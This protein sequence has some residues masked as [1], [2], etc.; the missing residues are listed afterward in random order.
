MKLSAREQ[1]KIKS[2]TYKIVSMIPYILLIVVSAIFI[3]TYGNVDG[4]A[5]AIIKVC[6]SI[7]NIFAIYI[8]ARKTMDVVRDIRKK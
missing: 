2:L 4:I 8:I 6:L 3:S 1:R 7:F 5:M